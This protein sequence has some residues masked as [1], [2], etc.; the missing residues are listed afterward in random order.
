M[1]VSYRASPLTAKVLDVNTSTPPSSLAPNLVW[2]DPKLL[3]LS[4]GCRKYEPAP[5]PT[6]GGIAPPSQLCRRSA[7][8]RTCRVESECSRS[9][10][11]LAQPAPTRRLLRAVR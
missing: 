8:T 1:T 10:F 9:T 6:N 5:A 11:G 2:L 4:I 7:P 3:P